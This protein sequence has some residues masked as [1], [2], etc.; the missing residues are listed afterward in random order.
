MFLTKKALIK[1]WL[2]T[3]VF[4]AL[5]LLSFWA[6]SVFS[7]F[8]ESGILLHLGVFCL[9][10][11][12]LAYFSGRYTEGKGKLI[13]RGRKLVTQQLRP[14]E[15]I[16]LYMEK[17]DCP[18][19]VV[20]K[21]DYE[22]LQALVGAYDAAG[23]KPGA[24]EAAEQM[25]AAAPERKKPIAKLTKAA[26]L[27]GLGR[28]EEAEQLYHQTRGEK[29]DLLATALADTILK[30][31]RAMAYSDYTTAELHFKQELART[32]PKPSPLDRVGANF[33]LALICRNTGRQE[34]ARQYL[35]Y[36]IEHGGET[37]MQSAAVDLWNELY[38]AKKT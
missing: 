33:A 27:F 2:V 21:P 32:F 34:E 17:R 9:S 10:F 19:N 31:T 12:P 5:A 23:D 8:F 26:I 24:L 37:G 16:R 36:C 25:L 20:A 18:D 35:R 3:G 15:F 30:G 4:L 29:M 7:Q 1:I 28:M 38:I 6:F 13:N 22:V 14:A 11:A